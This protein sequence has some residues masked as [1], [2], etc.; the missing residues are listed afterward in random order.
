MQLSL[1]PSQSDFGG[2]P[3]AIMAEE[4]KIDFEFPHLSIFKMRHVGDISALLSGMPNLTSLY[5]SECEC[6]PSL[7]TTAI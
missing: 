5:L 4:E 7:L 2:G 1:F 6:L 3:A